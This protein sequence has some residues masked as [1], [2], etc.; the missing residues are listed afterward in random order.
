M[1]HHQQL[2]ILYTFRRCPY[3]MRARMA[4]QTAGVA[5]ELREV[6]LR[7]KPAQMLAI[8]PKA[9]VPV[10]QL[11]DGTV[12]EES[13]EIMEWAF[14]QHDSKA[15]LSLLSED[16]RQLVSR[17]DFDFKPI[18]DRYKYFVNFP[19][20]SQIHYRDSAGQFLDELESRLEAHEGRGLMCR[21]RAVADMAIFPF[22]RQF[23]RV[24][25]RWFEQ[26]PYQRLRH[27]LIEFEA[28][29]LFTS[30]M[31]KYRAW[32]AGDPITHFGDQMQV[33]N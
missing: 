31:K 15:W 23:A 14:G 18:L 30:V 33:G 28:S 4:I 20:H 25:W 16:A 32:S 29:E 3:A 5:C 13:I 22:V 2:P 9:T 6:V 12:V 11:E 21:Q 8:S 10:L 26:S 17:S 19:E 27:W 7:D 1:N 24:D